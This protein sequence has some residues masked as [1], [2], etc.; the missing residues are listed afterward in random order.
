MNISGPKKDAC[1]WGGG[2][3]ITILRRR[4]LFISSKFFFRNRTQGFE[5]ISTKKKLYIPIFVTV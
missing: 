2:G 3:K 1:R 5:T 4:A